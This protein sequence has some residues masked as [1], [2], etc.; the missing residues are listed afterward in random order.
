VKAYRDLLAVPSPI[1]VIFDLDG[2]L[3]D[4]RLDFAAIR[5][6]A[7]VP[8]GVGLLEH[9]ETLADVAQR[10]RVE[11]IIHRHEMSGAESATWMPGA[12]TALRDIHARGLPSAIVTR[13]SRAAAELTMSRLQMPDIPLLAREDAPPKPDPGALLILA[14]AWGLPVERIAFVGDFH[15]DT[16]AAQRAGMIPV[17]YT[18]GPFDGGHSEELVILE[19]MHELLTWLD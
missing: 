11:A 15:F 7:D 2:T 17:L 1:A 13:N 4:S 16:E 12:D 19:H 18:N 9:L 6:E 5:R 10:A 8:D 14:E 3:V